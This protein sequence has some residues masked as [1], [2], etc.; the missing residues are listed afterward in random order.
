MSLNIFIVLIGYLLGS[1]PTSYLAGK[2]IKGIDLREHGSG[3]LGATNTLRVLG[4]TPGIAVLLIDILKGLAAVYLIKLLAPS[5][6]YYYQVVSGFL[7]IIGHNWSVFLK[8]S[9]G[10]GVATSCGVLIALTPL[11]SLILFSVF[12]IS[13]ALTR[14]ISVGSL[15]AAVLFP[16]ST[17]YFEK[18][19]PLI[20][21]AFVV[22]VLIIVKH[23]SNI[24]RLLS[25]T[26]NK[27]GN[28]VKTSK[29]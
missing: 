28:S 7:A 29:P 22:A 1:F 17:I 19:K 14:Y 8:F 20:I 23:K 4:K 3:N 26:E 11:I 9:G 24:Q 5:S 2:L 6:P 25:G 10:K 15:S 12:V 13:V 27:L 18:P 21:F 16:V